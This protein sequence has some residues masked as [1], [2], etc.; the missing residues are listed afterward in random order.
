M[1]GGDTSFGGTKAETRTGCQWE[2]PIEQRENVALSLDLVPRHDD[3][4]T[5]Y[6]ERCEDSFS[7]YT[8][9][10]PFEQDLAPKFSRKRARSGL[11]RTLLGG[12]HA[13]ASSC[14]AR[15]RRQ[16]PKRRGTRRR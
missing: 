1:Y 6:E 3:A 13:A 7:D 5:R 16:G 10:D 12:H 8:L 14:A 4:R 11:E 15:R 2:S 9:V